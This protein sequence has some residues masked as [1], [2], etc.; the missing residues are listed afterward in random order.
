MSECDASSDLQQIPSANFRRLRILFCTNYAWSS[1]LGAPRVLIELSEALSEY[2]HCCDH[3]SIENSGIT[4]NRFTAPF[5]IS[6]YRRKLL[7]HIRKHGSEYDVIHVEHRLLPYSRDK[8]K[9]KGLIVAKSV[10]LAHFYDEFHRTT[11]R[12]LK[13]KLGENE[14]KIGRVIRFAAKIHSGG[15]SS[16]NK[17]FENAD[18]ILLNNIAELEYVKDRLNHGEKCALVANA[19]A[20]SL[21]KSLSTETTIFQRQYSNVVAFIGTWGLRKGSYEIP[22]IIRNVRAA[23]PET[24]FRLIGTYTSRDIILGQLS[25]EDRAFV[26]VIP[27]FEPKELAKLLSDAKCG[28]F[29]SYIEGYPLGLLEMLAAGIPVVAWD[30]PGSQDIINESN[31]GILTPAGNIE[32]FSSSL[33][34]YLNDD[35]ELRHE[36]AKEWIQ[37]QCWSQMA[38][39]TQSQIAKL[40]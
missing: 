20:P 22:H 5:A 39:I 36:D 12:A 16:V 7:F 14:S 11:E 10:G 34:A 30:V 24:K 28:M 29:P 3:Y 19:L 40:L 38:D 35:V 8:H 37:K 4:S 27:A 25:P 9:Y 26:E 13:R 21:Y 33:L 31:F 15:L 32:K 6:R 23:R 2:G 17:T 1:K 18:L